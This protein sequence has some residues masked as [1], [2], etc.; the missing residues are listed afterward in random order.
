M[1]ALA[2]R[3]RHPAVIA[4]L[5]LLGLVVTGVAYSAFAPKPAQAA[6][7]SASQVEDGRKL[8][9][10]NCATCH[11]LQAQGT[12]NGP[13]LAGVGAASVD[14][15]V[16][17]GRMPMARPDVQAPDKPR[18]VRRRGGRRA[19]G[20][21]RLARSRPGHPG[22]GRLQRRGRRRRQ[23]RRAVPRQLRHVPQ[24]RRLR[25]C[26]HPRQVR[27]EPARRRGQARLRGDG[28]RPAVDARLQRHQHHPR[29]Q[30]RHH[31]LP[32]TRSTSRRT[33]GA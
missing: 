20:L 14:F 7:A 26:A 22:G 28:H 13:S 9:L 23:G 21:R 10:A 19:G 30:E 5:L 1:N 27:P 2:A 18:P 31:R 3:R 33:S 16:G 24:L 15:Q 25:R 4:L 29:G 8:F 32:R 12:R 17:T 11:G 6:P